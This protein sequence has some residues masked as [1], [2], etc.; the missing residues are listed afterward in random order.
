MNSEQLNKLIDKILYGDIHKVPLEILKDDFNEELLR[1]FDE[2]Q[3][4]RLGIAATIKQ[5]FQK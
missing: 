5:W 4:T 2:E 3:I 1:T